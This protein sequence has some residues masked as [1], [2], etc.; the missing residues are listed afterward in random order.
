[1]PDALILPDRAGSTT[2]SARSIRGGTGRFASPFPPG[3]HHSTMRESGSRGSPR[4]DARSDIQ[5]VLVHGGVVARPATINHGC[6]SLSS[7]IPLQ[8]GIKHNGL[9]RCCVDEVHGPNGLVPSSRH[10]LN[11]GEY[12]KCPARNIHCAPRAVLKGPTWKTGL[13]A[14]WVSASGLEACRVCVRQFEAMQ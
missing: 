12:R 1:M 8:G 9:G 7:V 4:A 13:G 2:A 5:Q 14:P 10:A 3:W 6:G 11:P